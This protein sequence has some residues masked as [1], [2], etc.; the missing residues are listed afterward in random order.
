MG[1]ANAICNTYGT[2][3]G[4]VVDFAGNTIYKYYFSSLYNRYETTCFSTKFLGQKIYR[5]RFKYREL[6]AIKYT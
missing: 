2:V 6:S 4:N 3:N 5:E 1:G